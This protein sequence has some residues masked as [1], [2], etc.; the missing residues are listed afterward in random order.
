MRGLGL[1]EA[2]AYERRHAFAIET[3]SIVYRVSVSRGESEKGLS[4]SLEKKRWR[5]GGG[6]SLS[7]RVGDEHV[8]TVVNYNEST[9][10]GDVAD[11]IRQRL[12]GH[13]APFG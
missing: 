5:S 10:S 2:I 3:A 4:R 7:Y 11:G 8:S 6:L 12:G 9:P 1:V 13:H